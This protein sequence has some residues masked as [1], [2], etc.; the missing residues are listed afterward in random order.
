MK[1]ANHLY[2]WRRK[3]RLFGHQA[4]KYY[5]E[6]QPPTAA[7]DSRKILATAW[8]MTKIDISY[9][10]TNPAEL[11]LEALYDD[12]QPGTKILV[13]CP[14]GCHQ[15]EI[16]SVSQGPT[17]IQ[18]PLASTVSKI[19]LKEKLPWKLDE[20][21]LRQVV[22][23]ELAGPE[24]E[25]W[26]YAYPNQIIT[27]NTF[28]VPGW[29]NL[30]PENF[31]R[32]RTLL[33]DDDQSQP[34]AVTVTGTDVDQ[35]VD[36]LAISFTPALPQERPLDCL[37][38]VCYG[39]VAR[40]TH[41]ETVPGEVLGN[42]DGAAVFQTFTLKKSP[43]TH[44]P[45]PLKPHGAA[46]TLEVRVDGVLWQEAETLYGQND[47]ARVYTTQVDDQGMMTITFGDG[48][49]GARL[50][51][52]RNNLVAK[53][54]QGLGREGN[55]ERKSLSTLLDRPVGLKG[56]IN[57]GEA[58]GGADP[59]TLSE[60]RANAPNTVRTFG[61][62][63]SLRDFEDVARE[64]AG[65][66][67]AR[68]T[69]SW[70]GEERVVHLT[71]AGPQGTEVNQGKIKD[72]VAY[73]NARRGHRRRLYV[74]SLQRV[75][76]RI[77][78][79]L[80]YEPQYLPEEVKQAARQALQDHFSEHV[81]LGQS[82]YLSHI[83]RIIQGVQGVA[84]VDIEELQFKAPERVTKY[85]FSDLSLQSRLTIFANEMASIEKPGEDI[86]FPDGIKKS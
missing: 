31:E 39:N 18:G 17:T 11:E 42:G 46:N 8:T 58:Y 7:D 10:L 23:Y 80:D 47:S 52:G 68:A 66:A 3:F 40:A 59:E 50:V 16:T 74:E 30:S 6:A 38:A 21:K 14:A 65:I 69:C 73:L 22:V 32:G 77:K 61:R 56:V 76:I 82:M 9:T 71:V 78:A 35:E 81:D 60:A 26:R 1:E 75:P 70:E 2:K 53:Y 12:L 4:P 67:K 36:H 27:G 83:F 44:V 29:L 79:A 24:I 13:T 84:A 33:L 28:Y 55:V 62:I 41:G 15:T 37:T 57:P 64:V 48:R 72:L 54:R 45:H 25:F 85:E 86:E 34:Y 20:I 19:T 5:I 51:S 63:V 43:V 49:T